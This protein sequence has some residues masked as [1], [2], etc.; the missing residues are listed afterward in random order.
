MTQ[1][2]FNAYLLEHKVTKVEPNDIGHIIHFDNDTWLEVY[3]Y[4]DELTYDYHYKG[5]PQMVVE[6]VRS[7]IPEITFL[8]QRDINMDISRF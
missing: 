1:E 4:Y 8:D 2:E 7:Y 6:N 5:E 3:C